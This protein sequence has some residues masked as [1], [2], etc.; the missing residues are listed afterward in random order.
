MIGGEPP[1]TVPVVVDKAAVEKLALPALIAEGFGDDDAGSDDGGSEDDE[2]DDG[3]SAST[4][5]KFAPP[6][7]YDEEAGVVFG[8]VPSFRIL[9]PVAFR[10]VRGDTGLHIDPT[11]SW[12]GRPLDP[13]DEEFDEP[14]LTEEAIGFA[15]GLESAVDVDALR[16]RLL[17]QPDVRAAAIDLSYAASTNGSELD[18]LLP[19]LL[20]KARAATARTLGAAVD[21]SG[22]AAAA[23]AAPTPGAA[24]VSGLAAVVLDAAAPRDDPGFALQDKRARDAIVRYVDEARSAF[25][26][27]EEEAQEARDNWV[28]GEDCE[29]RGEYVRG[30]CPCGYWKC[31]GD[32][33]E[34]APP[35]EDCGCAEENNPMP[36]PSE[37]VGPFGKRVDAIVARAD[38]LPENVREALLCG[39]AEGLV[40]GNCPVMIPAGVGRWR[41]AA[42]DEIGKAL[43]SALSERLDTLTARALALATGGRPGLL[44]KLIACRPEE[45]FPIDAIN[46]APPSARGSLI[47]AANEAVAAL[48][49]GLSQGTDCS[50]ELRASKTNIRELLA[51]NWLASWDV[52]AKLCALAGAAFQ[53]PRVGLVEFALEVAGHAKAPGD[54]L[55]ATRR[56]AVAALEAWLSRTADVRIKALLSETDV[57]DAA[58]ILRAIEAADVGAGAAAA[59]RRSMEKLASASRWDAWP[60]IARV[61]LDLD[62]DASAAAA[63][64]GAAALLSHDGKAGAAFM[65]TSLDW[66]PTDRSVAA[67]AFGTCRPEEREIVCDVALDEATRPGVPPALLASVLDDVAGLLLRAKPV[68]PLADAFVDR[69][70]GL[71]PALAVDLCEAR[72]QSLPD[73]KRAARIIIAHGSDEA[74]VSFAR[75]QIVKPPTEFSFDLDEASFKAMTF[76]HARYT[77]SGYRNYTYTPSSWRGL[78]LASVQSALLAAAG[79]LVGMQVVRWPGVDK[80][81]ALEKDVA[82]KKLTDA[83]KPATVIFAPL[84]EGNTVGPPTETF[85]DASAAHETAVLANHAILQREYRARVPD[86]AW[87]HSMLIASGRRSGE[88][89]CALTREAYEGSA[90]AWFQSIAKEA[91]TIRKTQLENRCT[92][93]HG[94]PDLVFNCHCCARSCGPGIRYMARLKA[95]SMAGL[96]GPTTQTLLKET[97][98][99]TLL[100]LNFHNRRKVH[101]HVAALQTR[102]FPNLAPICV[103]EQRL[104]AWEGMRMAPY[105]RPAPPAP[106]APPEPC[107]D[108]ADA[109]ASWIKAA[110]GPPVG[111]MA[112]RRATEEG[113]DGETL[114]SMG[115]SE[116]REVLM[117]FPPGALSAAETMLAR[118]LARR[119]A[120]TV[121]GHALSAEALQAGFAAWVERDGAVAKLATL[122]GM[123][124]GE[125]L[126]AMEFDGEIDALAPSIMSAHHVATV[127]SP[128]LRAARNMLRHAETVALPP[129]PETLHEVVVVGFRGRAEIKLAKPA[130]I[131]NRAGPRAPASRR[132]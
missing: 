56:A 116:I 110:L 75:A 20:A 94:R 2:D 119:A 117:G 24:F 88:L 102:S 114:R 42:I 82:L 30:E 45:P 43:G 19:K 124:D 47:A 80:V 33:G 107:P 49:A 18:S 74:L 111:P 37:A 108:D 71:R 51:R 25:E 112:A 120:G 98:E 100:S 34:E 121:R 97:C 104:P 63:T 4:R 13:D 118:K 79:G 67:V 28:A 130:R 127:F 12:S 122:P 76:T 6:A 8:H 123:L 53:A 115:E 31:Y 84:D 73:R 64:R 26:Q 103:E 7:F 126:A 32:C 14:L 87:L 72:V 90:Q 65:K 57:V 132:C 41:R 39:V 27:K 11:R 91:D 40:R 38:A 66:L 129:A 59:A 55:P 52:V 92:S 95:L 3:P 22:A 93:S 58:V 83:P 9:K 60:T 85:R 131:N 68:L 16:A 101:S 35:L 54:A 78:K 86:V 44:A 46:A 113:I 89:C 17:A 125:A 62:R 1:A 15:A 106:V 105:A 77:S 48:S 128:R 81:S 23:T 96:S 36:R 109:T 61:A 50:S 99:K 21:A 69:V 70:A 5:H 29:C 10:A